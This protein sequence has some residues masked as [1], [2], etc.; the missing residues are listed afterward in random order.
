MRW[1]IN[2]A[3]HPKVV[4]PQCKEVYISS[5]IKQKRNLAPKPCSD[6]CAKSFY[7]SKHLCMLCDGPI[8]NHVG[9]CR[10]CRSDF[11]RGI[12]D[13]YDPAKGATSW[14]RPRS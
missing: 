3:L 4:C 12:K 8:G 11:N 14:M 9:Y 10:R 1:F 5:G 6:A 13:S 2:R 7:N